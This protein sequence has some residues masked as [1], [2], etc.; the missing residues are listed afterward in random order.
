ML[1]LFRD[2]APIFALMR[3]VLLLLFLILTCS[4]HAA[5]RE[6]TLAREML[7]DSIVRNDVEGMQF[8]RARLVRLTAESD[9]RTVQRDAHYL[10]ALSVSFESFSGLGDVSPALIMAGVRHADRAVELDPQ[11]AEGWAM[12]AMLRGIARRAGQTVPDDPPGSPNRFARAKELD[13]KAPAVAFFN[14]MLTSMNPNGA[15]PPEGVKMFDELASRLEAERKGGRR[16][17]LWDAETEAWRLFV[18]IA[19]DEPQAATLRPMVARLLEQRPDFALGR[20]IADSVNERR[21]VAPPALT[22]QP[23]LTDAASDGKNPKLPDVISVDRAEDA[24]RIWVR[25]GFRETLPRSF[26]VNLVVDRDGDPSTGMKWW[27]NGSSFRFDRLVTAWISRDG[28][29]YFGR[30]G[31]TDDTGA[32]AAKL[33]KITTDVAVAMGADERSVM[34]GVPRGAL[35]WTPASTMIVAGGSHLVWNDDAASAVNSR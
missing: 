14:G 24:E 23:L 9:D 5:D 1:R 6:L 7:E 13:P 27:G 33:M 10:A 32:R 2:A 19:Q 34:I 35:G 26:G 11:F 8:A 17:G 25:V 30:V 16:F 29:R 3:N 4:T 20:E 18:R 31:V 28:D 15:A 12:S 21:F 22:W